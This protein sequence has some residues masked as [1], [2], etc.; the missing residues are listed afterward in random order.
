MTQIKNKTHIQ[1]KSKSHEVEAMGNGIF[2][3]TSCTS[4]KTYTVAMREYG[5]TCNCKWGQYRKWVTPQSGCSHVVSAFRFSKKEQ[6]RSLSV[7]TTPESAKRQKKQMINIWD[8]VILT[9]RKS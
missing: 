6:G 5:A 3:V 9:T 2:K 4:G 8:G 1:K 7:W